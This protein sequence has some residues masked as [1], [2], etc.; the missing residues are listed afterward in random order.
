MTLTT[1]RVDVDGKH[2]ARTSISLLFARVCDWLGQAALA[3][4]IVDM[5]FSIILG[6][7]AIVIWPRLQVLGSGPGS[8]AGLPMMGLM[9]ATALGVPSLL[10]GIFD[11][12]R[13]RFRQTGR[14][15]V[16]VGPLAIMLRFF[17]VVHALDPCVRGWLTLESQI[18]GIPLCEPYLTKLNIHTRLHLLHHAMVPTSFLAGLY[19]MSL[20]RWYPRMTHFR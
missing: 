2:I 11:L 9:A 14:L 5:L 18:A 13:G 4:I 3:I 16:F 8:G 19:W 7:L 10:L 15:L 17:F 20:R 6:I 12:L 1:N